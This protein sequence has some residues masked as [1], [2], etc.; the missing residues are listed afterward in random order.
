MEEDLVS[1]IGPYILL[2][3]TFAL[4]ATPTL[5]SAVR[6]KPPPFC[7][8]PGDIKGRHAK[9]SPM[10]EISD[11]KQQHDSYFDQ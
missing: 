8:T 7:G 2:Q 6:L 1:N 4:P 5:P 11:P 3:Y 9:E 10:A